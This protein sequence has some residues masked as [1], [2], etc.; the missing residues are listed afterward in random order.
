MTLTARLFCETIAPLTQ[1]GRFEHTRPLNV[2]SFAPPDPAA[3][4]PARTT[5][6]AFACFPVMQGGAY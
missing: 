1:L 4:T 2:H 6:G 3:S 5:G